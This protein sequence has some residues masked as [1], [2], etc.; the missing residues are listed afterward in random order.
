MRIVTVVADGQERIGALRGDKVAEL[1]GLPAGV[2][3]VKGLLAAV[4]PEALS[5]VAS[6]ETAV[7][8]LDQ[9]ELRPPV[10][11]PGKIICVGV[12]YRAHREETKHAAIEWP[13]IFTR[14]ADTQIADGEPARRPRATSRFDYEGELAVVLGRTAHHVGKDAAWSHIAGVSLYNDFSVRDWQKHSTQWTPGKNFPGTGAFGPALVTLDELPDLSEPAKV[15][16]TT[17]VNGET[18]Q[19]ATLA[20]L[21]FDIPSL[22]E[23]ISGFTALSPGDVIVTGTPGGVGQFMDPPSFL[24]DGDRVEVEVS[25]VGV[26][27]NAVVDEP[28]RDVS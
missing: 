15:T 9:V 3:D 25:G 16:L 1:I 24:E 26:L 14:F 21:I 2:K 10:P 11:N 23:Y 5:S 8:A 19:N 28:G 27:R 17:R 18:R 12:N 7:W 22:I 6:S 4:S 20:D 13:T